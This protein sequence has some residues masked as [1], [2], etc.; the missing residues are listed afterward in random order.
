M[1][2]LRWC[3]AGKTQQDTQ[4]PIRWITNLP[5]V[6]TERELS[7]KVG[8]IEPRNSETFYPGRASGKIRLVRSPLKFWP[9]FALAA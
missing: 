1:R 6:G 8:T 9:F 4:V 3:E 7:T 5:E 2:I